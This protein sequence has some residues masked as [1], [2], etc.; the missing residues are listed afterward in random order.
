MLRFSREMAGVFVSPVCLVCGSCF[1]QKNV[2]IRDIAVMAT[3][4]KPMAQDETTTGA[5]QDAGLPL[6]PPPFRGLKGE[7]SGAVQERRR[8]WELLASLGTLA[9]A[10]NELP[11]CC[12]G[13]DFLEACT[14]RKLA[15]FDF[16]SWVE[17]YS[18][19]MPDEMRRIATRETYDHAFSGLEKGKASG[20]KLKAAREATISTYRRLTDA[21]I[22]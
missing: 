17:G 6:D 5:P 10:T 7:I 11:K 4:P 13:C 14:A 21:P 9:V 15:C 1:Y 3:R 20:E 19:E 2:Q 16:L 18:L 12:T 8:K 22:T